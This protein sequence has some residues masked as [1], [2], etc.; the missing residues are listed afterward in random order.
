M[1]SF[2]LFIALGSSQNNTQTEP[3]AR[4]T[5]C[6][7]TWLSVVRLIRSKIKYSA[8]VVFRESAVLAWILRFA[9]NDR[10]VHWI[11]AT[12]RMTRGVELF[13][14]REVDSWIFRFAQNDIFFV[15]P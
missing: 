7:Y 9:Q 4:F 1:R 2:R 12:L 11:F 13:R 15:S 14:M 10:K 8:I 6:V 3:V 5:S